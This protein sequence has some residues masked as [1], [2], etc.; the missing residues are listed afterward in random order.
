MQI[1]YQPKFINSFNNN[2]GIVDF[3]GVYI[4]VYFQYILIKTPKIE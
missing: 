4:G 1:I 3:L 2:L